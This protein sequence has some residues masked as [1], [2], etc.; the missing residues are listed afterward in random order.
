GPGVFKMDLALSEAIPWQ[1]EGCRGAGTVHVGGTY[2]EVAASESAC[3]RG[4][5]AERPFVLLAQ[6]SVCDGTRAPAGKHTCW[7]YCHV[8]HGSE[9][10][11]SEA[12]LG[13]IERF[14]PGF[15]ETILETHVMRCADFQAYNPNYVGGDIVGGVQDLAQ[16]W[17]RPVARFDPYSTPDEGI[18]ICS[19]ST[20]P[21]A[22]VHGMGG[23]FAARS[24]LRRVFGNRGVGR[25]VHP[26]AGGVTDGDG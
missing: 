13:Q 21:G 3:W 17:T 7:A 14:A 2:E 11:M 1:A 8:P 26:T 23:Y 19:S 20:P 22:G 25:R 24:V 10:D 12:L 6:Q 18:F 9:V 5:H 16:Q 15:R 4:E